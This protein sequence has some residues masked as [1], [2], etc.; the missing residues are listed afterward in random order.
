MASYPSLNT[1]RS[2]PV[3]LFQSV[4][5]QLGAGEICASQIGPIKPCTPEVA[6]SQRCPFQAAEAE[7]CI[8]EIGPIQSGPAEIGPL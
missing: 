5:I 3:G 7:V 8:A 4:L 6:A 1:L 2:T